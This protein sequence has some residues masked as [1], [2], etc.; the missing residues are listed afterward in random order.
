MS[1]AVTS[2]S[3]FDRAT[4]PKGYWG[5][6][7]LQ[8][9]RNRPAMAGLAVILVL[10]S[11]AV[12]A[13][14]LANDR[15]IVARFEGD[16]KF[17]AFTGYVDSWVPWRS[18][19][20]TLKSW[21]IGGAFPFSDHYPELGGRTWTDLRGTADLGFA[22]WPPVRFNPNQ[23]DSEAVRQRPS[24]ATRHLIGTD[25]Q[26]RDV[27]ARLIHGTVVAVTVGVIAMGI[28]AMIGITLGLIAGWTENSA[29][30]LLLTRKLTACPNSS[31]GP[32]LI[33]SAARSG[34]PS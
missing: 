8:L 26:G 7:W 17:P 13:P 2:T 34:A 11:V 10:G 14:L 22:V 31:M 33:F 5:I 27:L 28:A 1:A 21:K 20:N 30:L 16:T 4:G 12:L 23:F 6:T 24:I 29:E 19:R 18:L 25:D 32:A 15:P 3:R 9:R